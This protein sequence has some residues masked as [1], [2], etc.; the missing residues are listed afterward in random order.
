MADQE[1]AREP[2]H[3]WA[4]MDRIPLSLAKTPPASMRI[5][6][7]PRERTLSLAVP[8]EEGGPLVRRSFRDARTFQVSDA[9]ALRLPVEQPDHRYRLAVLFELW[10]SQKT[11]RFKIQ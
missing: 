4:Q 9:Y 10:T 5:R 3:L 6:I 7:S 1:V 8:T 11:V 2:G